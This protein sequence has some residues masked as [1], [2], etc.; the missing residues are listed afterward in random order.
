MNKNIA[1]LLGAFR[2]ATID[3]REGKNYEIKIA[4]KNKKWLYLIQKL[5]GAEFGKEGNILRHTENYW[6]LRLSDKRIVKELLRLS[7]MKVPQEDWNTPKKIR[8]SNKRE[9]LVNYIQGFFDAEGGLPKKFEKGFQKYIIFSQK[10]K[11]SLEFIHGYLKKWKIYP[12]NL[13]QCGGVWEFRVTRKQSILNFIGVIGSSHPE[14]I[15]K[16]NLFK[17]VLAS[18]N[19]RGSTQG[20]DA[21]VQLDSTPEILLAATVE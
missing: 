12:T 18:P 10:N 21:A 2:D 17:R 8:S 5:L 14:K 6:I 16:L 3:I 19:W 9:I 13:T 11:E 7:E 1:Y 15:D 4:Q 20:V